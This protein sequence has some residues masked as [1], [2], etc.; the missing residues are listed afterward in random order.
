MVSVKRWDIISLVRKVALN[1]LFDFEDELTGLNLKK[2][3]ESYV[4][5]MT[6]KTGYIEMEGIFFH[7]KEPKFY[8]S[9]KAC[10]LRDFLIFVRTS[11]IKYIELYV[12]RS[13]CTKKM[14]NHWDFPS[15]KI[16]AKCKVFEPYFGYHCHLELD[17]DIDT[18]YT[19]L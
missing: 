13:R 9:V 16:Y 17:A 10:K 19:E 15:L 14:Y 18:V 5:G 3:K 7:L 8:I 2:I 11:H 1:P 12:S 6:T 4:F